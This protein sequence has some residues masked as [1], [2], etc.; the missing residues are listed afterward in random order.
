MTYDHDVELTH[1]APDTDPAVVSAHL[2]QWG[3]A[4]IDD[5][6][7]QATMDQLEAE[8]MPYITASDAGR[9]EYD[10]RHTRRTGMLIAR[11]PTARG[12]VM[13]LNVLGGLSLEPPSFQRP[14]PLLLLAYLAL[15]GKK[16]KRTKRTSAE[17]NMHCS[18]SL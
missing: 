2:R 11:C 9:D 7:D 10:G 17:G 4:I 14:K 3:Y 16:E 12:M 6:A 18:Y 15:E 5:V 8:A 1:F 13:H